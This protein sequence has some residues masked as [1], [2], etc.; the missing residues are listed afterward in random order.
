MTRARKR[1]FIYTNSTLFD[2]LPADIHQVDQTPY[3]FPDEVT[4]QLSHKDVNLG[5]FKSRKKDILSLRSG[6]KLCFANNLLY[7]PNNQQ[8]FVAQLSQKMQ[9]ELAQW[10][11]KGY[12]VSSATIRFVV[13]WKPKDA[14]KDEKEYA[15]LLLD[16]E[17]KKTTNTQK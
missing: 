11:S 17:L 14:P 9:A 8:L 13:A 16:L 3:G 7:V 5:F 2:R 12:L 4:L 1:L 6:E 10:A 15:V